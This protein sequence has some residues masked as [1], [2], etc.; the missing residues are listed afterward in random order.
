MPLR[1]L[2]TS[3]LRLTMLVNMNNYLTLEEVS[4]KL[5]LSLR[6]VYRFVHSGELAAA[7][8]GAIWRVSE[9]DLTAFFESR[10]TRKKTEE[11]KTNS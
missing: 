10:K 4:E 11:E 2:L 3:C 1:W 7:K 8:I 5:K 6:Q 9:A